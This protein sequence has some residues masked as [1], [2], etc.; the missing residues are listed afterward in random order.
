[1]KRILFFSLFLICSTELLAQNNEPSQKFHFIVIG[2]SF[3]ARFQEVSGLDIETQIIEY[4]KSNSPLFGTVKMPGIKKY[5]NVI[6]KKGVMV[7]MTSKDF[8][9]WKNAIKLNTIKRETV[10]IKLVDENDE[11]TM[12]WR[13]IN[14]WPTKITGTD[15]S[16]EGDEVTIE[17]IEFNHEGLT[18]SPR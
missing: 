3:E 18:V 10:L 12:T 5:G 9:K 8:L 7:N 1:M 16:S 2:E 15:L 11:T 6:M 4:R 14:V 13:L 17:S